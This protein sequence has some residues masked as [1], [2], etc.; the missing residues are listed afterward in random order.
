MGEWFNGPVKDDYHEWAVL[1][2]LEVP[3]AR[4]FDHFM[5]F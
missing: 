2:T 3:V 5:D 4:A 1:R